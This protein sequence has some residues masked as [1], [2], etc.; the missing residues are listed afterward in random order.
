MEHW[1][2]K[3]SSGQFM[4]GESGVLGGESG[5][6]GRKNRIW[7]EFVSG[8]WGHWEKRDIWGKIGLVVS[9]L[10][11]K[12]G[13]LRGKSWIWGEFEETKGNIGEKTDFG[14]GKRVFNG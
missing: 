13:V 14:R 6:L 5:V 1:G 8:K 3:W 11:G 10:R 2:E 9:L 4:R 7:G 12:M